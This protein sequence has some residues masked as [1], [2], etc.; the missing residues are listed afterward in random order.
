MLKTIPTPIG[1][2][3]TGA[4]LGGAMVAAGAGQPAAAADEHAPTVDPPLLFKSVPADQAAQA[5]LLGDADE[6]GAWVEHLIST[7]PPTDPLTDPPAVAPGV[8]GAP[9]APACPA[10]PGTQDTAQ[11]RNIQ[12]AC[13]IWSPGAT[14]VASATQGAPLS[15]GADPPDG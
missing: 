5:I 6:V 1:V 7:L 3:I 14:T 10:E 15:Q 12:R 8:P 4:V 13:N 9:T 11:P 2:T